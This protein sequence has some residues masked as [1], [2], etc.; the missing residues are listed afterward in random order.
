MGND[1]FVRVPRAKLQYVRDLLIEKV[2]GSHARSPSHNAR[3][4]V[5]DMLAAPP[6]APS[7]DNVSTPSE[8]EGSSAAAAGKSREGMSPGMSGIVSVHDVIDII[9]LAMQRLEA[10]D[11]SPGDVLL[12][13]LSDASKFLSRLQPAAASEAPISAE[14]VDPIRKSLFD[15][16]NYWADRARKAEAVN[17]SPDVAEMVERLNRA[18]DE[19]EIEMQDAHDAGDRPDLW[20][21]VVELPIKEVRSAAS[22]LQSLARERES[23]RSSRNEVIEMCLAEIEQAERDYLS[24]DQAFA[25]IPGR[26]RSLK[27]NNDVTA[28]SHGLSPALR[29]QEMLE[30]IDEAADELIDSVQYLQETMAA[31]EGV[32]ESK[33]IGGVM[34]AHEMLLILRERLEHADAW[35]CDGHGDESGN[36]VCK[37]DEQIAALARVLKPF[38]DVATKDIG[39]DEVDSDS[40]RVMSPQNARADLLTVG[41]FRRAAAEFAALDEPRGLS[42]SEQSSNCEAVNKENG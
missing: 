39:H 15:A 26:L 8:L 25:A 12:M 28:S 40:F 13:E 7:G 20:D 41:D 23:L 31:G 11:G 37:K 27:D 30:D 22:L 21:Q 19:I 42:A 1:D 3:L 32:Y 36:F 6:S 18:V 16:K 2:Y 17:Q 34:R 4:E 5:D 14:A 9:D 10:M 35:P 33:W 24:V 29:A 38:V